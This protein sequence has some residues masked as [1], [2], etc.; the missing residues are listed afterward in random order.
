MKGSSLT[1][2]VVVYTSDR[3]HEVHLKRALLEDEG[4]PCLISDENV[5]TWFPHLAQAVGGIKLSVPRDRAEDALALLNER[6]F[7]PQC[8][9][10]GSHKTRFHQ[11]NT[12]WSVLVSILLYIP[13]PVYR[14]PHW[15]CSDCKHRWTDP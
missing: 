4:I 9:S 15:V 6:V 13:V 7:N 1:E 14:E 8:P 5:T 11:L 3:S 2:S 12:F 10:C